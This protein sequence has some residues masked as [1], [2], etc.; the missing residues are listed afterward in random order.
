MVRRAAL[1]IKKACRPSERFRHS[2]S[3]FIGRPQNSSS[4]IEY[5]IYDIGVFVEYGVYELI[6]DVPADVLRV[7]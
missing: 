7:E 4:V 1:S 5:K 2:L 3:L 6:H